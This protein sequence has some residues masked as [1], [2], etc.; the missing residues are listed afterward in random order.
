MTNLPSSQSGTGIHFIG[1]GGT[2]LSAV[3]RLLLE[4]GYRVTGSDRV[5]SPLAVSLQKAGAQ[6]YSGHDAKNVQGASLVIRSSA[7][8]DDNPEVQ[9]ALAAGIPVLKRADFLGQLMEGRTGIAIAGTHGK[10]TTT[11]MIAWMLTAL[12]QDPT[13]II[14]SVAA[15]LGTNAHS[16]NGAAFVIEADEYDNMF[17][18]LRPVIAVVTN[19]EHDHP[20]CFPTPDDYYGA[21]LAFADRLSPTGLLLACGD[22]PGAAR[23]LA[24]ARSGSRRKL[25]YSLK[26]AQAAYYSGYVIPNKCGGFDAQL[27][28]HQ[29]PVPLSLQVPGV[30]N[31]LNGLASVG[32][33]DQLGLD[34]VR[35]AEALGEYRGAD[36]RFQV[37]AETGGII[38]IDDYAHHPTEIRAT[39]AAARARYPGKKIWAVWQPHTY[40]RT[41]ALLNDFAASFLDADHIIVTEVYAAREAAPDDGFSAQQVVAAMCY[42]DVHF[43]PDLFEATALLLAFLQPGDVLLV[44]SA[45]DADQISTQ[46]IQGLAEH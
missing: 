12:G 30:H 34:V 5:L 32:V 28:I 23:L 31:L 2:G 4:M 45:G 21:F 15:N 8:P 43:V 7:I 22:D 40:S 42:P 10:T 9:A 1:I 27:E 35:A 33:A 14:G 46:V 36:R 26:N 3:A 19:I 44:L 16:G 37:R 20:D 39:L 38:V 41:R 29:Q 17:L 18:G 11:A 25:A 24:E 13:Y 6:V